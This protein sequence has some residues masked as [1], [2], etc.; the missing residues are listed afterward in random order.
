SKPILIILSKRQ[1][2]VRYLSNRSTTPFQRLGFLQLF[3]YSDHVLPESE[4]E[5]GVRFALRWTFGKMP[6][7]LL[8]SFIPLRTCL[9]NLPP[10]WANA[11]VEQNKAPQNVVL[12]LTWQDPLAGGRTRKGY[13]GWSG[14][15]STTQSTAFP[16]SKE[17]QT[18]V[19]EI[20]PQFGQYIGLQNGQN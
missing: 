6:R 13:V 2:V 18:D 16:K 5:I 14:T 11:F 8:V 7:E 9:V 1:R 12:E 4:S 17:A 19:L 3:K 10:Q 15:A 20:D